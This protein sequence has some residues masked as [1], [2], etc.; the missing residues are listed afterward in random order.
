MPD[1]VA[2]TVAS[3][4]YLAF[5]RVFT[6][7]FLT[8]NPGGTVF[9][10]VTDRRDPSID[11]AAEPFEAL[12]VE[13]LE[14]PAFE[15][16]AFR[17]SLLE[18]NTAVK[19][20]FLQSLDERFGL[21]SVCYFDPDIQVFTDLENLYS[22]FA[23]NHLLLTPHILGPLD[24]D[25][26]PSE[27]EFLLAG[28]YNLG[29]LGIAFD[30]D[31]R[32]LLN[33]WRDRLYRACL[34]RVDLG[35]FVDQRWMDFAPAFLP[36]VKIIRDPGYNVAYWNL[37]HRFPRQR[38]G[39]WWVGDRPLRFFHFS[40]FMPEN[41]ESVSKHQD[42]ITFCERPE[43]ATLFDTYR[44]L[45]IEAGLSDTCNLRNAFSIFDNG[46]SIPEVARSELRMIDDRGDRWP[47]PFNTESG[48]TYYG[49]LTQKVGSPEGSWLPR[50][51]L[52][53]WDQ[54]SD[55]QQAF[56]DP[57]GINRP[58]FRRW[59]L[60]GEP[61]ASGIQGTFF[62]DLARQG[63]TRAEIHS[64]PNSPQPGAVASLIADAGFEPLERPV[65]P[66]LA[67]LIWRERPDLQ[68]AFAAP[69]GS[70]RR[71]FARWYV[72]FARFEYALSD[73]LVM[74][75]LQSMS[76]HDRLRSRAWHWLASRGFRRVSKR[77]SWQNVRGVQKQPLSITDR[78]T[79]SG[80]KPVI[81]D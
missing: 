29:F 35:L 4:N 23:E 39:R 64:E 77:G 50:I 75:T 57:L 70:N 65:I 32:S 68:Q 56:P 30:N 54:R 31:T 76:L 6:R 43:L 22:L 47:F 74:P 58:A 9:V 62:V 1:R 13:D 78:D 61:E 10:L 11:Y 79:E 8:H 34:N 3:N 41:P 19:P 45:L 33:W 26:R 60:S 2:C 46:V 42:R 48:D 59:L 55:L 44:A 15:H 67:M 18:L 36:R 37:A 20:F 38:D 81:S 52:L 21:P 53:L 63:K 66:R 71:C 27:R 7:S 40:G 69:L 5:A 17:Y 80:V 72:T 14:I 25:R 51:A 12:F 49:W 28:I 16:F 24:D 73:A